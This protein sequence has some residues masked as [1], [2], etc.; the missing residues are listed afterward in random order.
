MFYL[1]ILHAVTCFNFYLSLLF[2]NYIVFQGSVK[3]MLNLTQ[4]E[5][6][7]RIE[8]LNQAL[9]ESWEQ[10]QRV[11]ALKIG[12]QVILLLLSYGQH[13]LLVLFF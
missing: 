5:Y 4:Q 13:F 12:I 2:C 7:N 10:D 8:E 9:R 6:V 1:V 3:E 11:K